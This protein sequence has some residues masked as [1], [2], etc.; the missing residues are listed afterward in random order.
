M[1]KNVNG[2]MISPIHH[3]NAHLLGGDGLLLPVPHHHIHGLA[4]EARGDA[5]ETALL[6]WDW[7]ERGYFY[8]K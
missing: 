7:G 4:A 1:R 2:I 5:L 3:N 8:C 6:A